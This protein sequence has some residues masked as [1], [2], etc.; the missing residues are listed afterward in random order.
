M[1]HYARFHSVGVPTGA[2]AN[3]FQLQFHTADNLL[4]VQWRALAAPYQLQTAL[5]QLIE[6]VRIQGIS[7]WLLDLANMP[8][9]G[10]VGLQ[11]FDADS[12]QLL[13]KLPLQQ[14]AVVL[15][16]YQQH[17]ELLDVMLRFAPC[18]EVQVFDEAT[19]ALEW[20]LQPA[21]PQPNWGFFSQTT[22]YAA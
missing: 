7:R 2:L 12:L 21:T 3:C 4:Q 10:P 18:F 5:G 20:L 15:T 14:V 13:A 16:S 17:Q 8:M 22:S 11:A 1:Y 19:T 6:L 9:V